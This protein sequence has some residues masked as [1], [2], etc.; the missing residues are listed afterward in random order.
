MTNFL[1]SSKA[2]DKKEKTTPLVKDCS[3]NH[4]HDKTV[5]DKVTELA[6][7]LSLK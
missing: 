5:D 2:D 7:I 1:P 3:P 6:A 4:V